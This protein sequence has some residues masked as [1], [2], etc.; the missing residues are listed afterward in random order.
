MISSKV[1]T[2]PH[3]VSVIEIASSALENSAFI[4]VPC[5]QLSFSK[6]FRTEANMFT[7]HFQLHHIFCSKRDRI[8]Q[9]AMEEA[10]TTASAAQLALLL[11]VFFFHF[12]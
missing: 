9:L 5:I 2:E 11:K 12:S 6:Q 1:F 7:Q 10:K 8:E 4:I 3:Y